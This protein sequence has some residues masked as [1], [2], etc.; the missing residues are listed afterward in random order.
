MNTLCCMRRSF[1][2]YRMVAIANSAAR[3]GEVEERD[4]KFLVWTCGRKF[5]NDD[6]V[7]YANRLLGLASAFLASVLSSRAL[8]ILWHGEPAVGGEEELTGCG[9]E[10]S[11]QLHNF[12]R[13]SLI[14]W[15]FT[16]DV[17]RVIGDPRSIPWTELDFTT[18]HVSEWDHSSRVVL[19]TME[20]ADFRDLWRSNREEILQLGISKT[21]FELGVDDQEEIMGRTL[22]LLLQPTGKMLEQVNRFHHLAG[23]CFVVGL[24]GSSSAA[25]CCPEPYHVSEG[26]DV[27]EE[28]DAVT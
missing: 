4:R 17:K 12:F 16:E 24:Q 2:V 5:R 27:D 20:K 18:R 26:E 28:S 3:P 21:L 10:E 9:G 15:R 23:G 1:K 14:D 25:T 22:P 7:G 11:L 8:I 19:V 13:S 6:C